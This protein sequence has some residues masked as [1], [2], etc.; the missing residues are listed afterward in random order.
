MDCK[1]RIESKIEDLCA[2]Y[3]HSYSTDA[4][5][6]D[7]HSNPQRHTNVAATISR[8]DLNIMSIDIS[9]VN[10]TSSLEFRF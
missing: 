9:I 1:A 10:L 8:E 6:I 5:L 4:L 2:G 7:C 3:P